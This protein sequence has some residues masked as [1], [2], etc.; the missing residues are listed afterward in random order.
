ME[1]VK[2]NMYVDDMMKSTNT[3]EKAVVLVSQLQELLRRGG[4]HLTKWYSN[5]RDVLAAIPESERANIWKLGLREIA[6]R[7]CSRSQMEHRGIQICV[8]GLGE[9]LS[10]R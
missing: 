10:S 9:D 8:G 3:T 4:F 7:I 6:N 2:R 5:D 1:T